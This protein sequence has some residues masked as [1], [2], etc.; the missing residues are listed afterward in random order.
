[1]GFKEVSVTFQESFKGVSRMFQSCF[2]KASR[3]IEVCLN[4]FLGAQ[5][6]L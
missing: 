6:P 3:E 2:V 4:R 5:A 1:M